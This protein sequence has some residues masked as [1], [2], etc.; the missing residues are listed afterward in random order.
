M[1]NVGA[2]A[3][4]AAY[5]LPGA[6][7]LHARHCEASFVTFDDRELEPF[8]DGTRFDCFAA[9]FRI[10]KLRSNGKLMFRQNMRREVLR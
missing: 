8:S 4:F 6:S 5:S 1:V 10:R 3:S 7:F 2:S 9:A